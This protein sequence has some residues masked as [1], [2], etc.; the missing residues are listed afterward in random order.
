MVLIPGE[1]TLPP[2]VEP[3]ETSHSIGARI[4]T[5]V[6]Q[7]DV[8]FPNDREGVILKIRDGDQ[9]QQVD[10]TLSSPPGMEPPGIWARIKHWLQ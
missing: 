6:R 4:T 7:L 9:E 3:L 10:L 5:E 1:R 2:M 8:R